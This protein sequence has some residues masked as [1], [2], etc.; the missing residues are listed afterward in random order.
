MHGL[1]P[2]ARRPRVTVDLALDGVR[3][4]EALPVL[5]LTRLDGRLSMTRGEKGSSSARVA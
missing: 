3:L 5:E 4:G 1:K 2:M